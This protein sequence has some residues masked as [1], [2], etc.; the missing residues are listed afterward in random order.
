MRPGQSLGKYAAHHQQSHAV[1][2]RTHTHLNGLDSIV[3]MYFT[4]GPD[5]PLLCWLLARY[6][7]YWDHSKTYGISS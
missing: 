5:A 6:Y 7:R 3:L 2:E 4:K 1:M